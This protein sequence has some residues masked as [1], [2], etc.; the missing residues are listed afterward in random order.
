MNKFAK[1]NKLDVESISAD[2]PTTKINLEDSYEDLVDE[3]K[4]NIFDIN[5]TSD[6]NTTGNKK[7]HLNLYSNLK[8]LSNKIT[9]KNKYNKIK[10][11]MLLCSCILLMIISLIFYNKSLYGCK[12]NDPQVCLKE[13]DEKKI[14]RLLQ[15]LFVSAFLFNISICIVLFSNIIKLIKIVF[16]FIFSIIWY[17]HISKDQG[18]DFKNHGSFNT[19]AF[20]IFNLFAFIFNIAIIVVLKVYKKSKFLSLLIFALFIYL[21]MNINYYFKQPTCIDWEY[22]FN[23]NS[24]NEEQFSTIEKFD[25]NSIDSNNINDKDI[26]KHRS[27]INNNIDSACSITTPLVCSRTILKGMFDITKI[28]NINCNN[29]PANKWKYN[30]SN[31]VAFP[32]IENLLLSANRF[33]QYT[34]KFT[35]T[36]FNNMIEI[37]NDKD[38][39]DLR[40]EAYVTKDYNNND[41]GTLTIDLKNNQLLSD[42]MKFKAKTTENNNLMPKNVFIIFIDSTSRVHFKHSLPKTYSFI[43][44]YYSRN[45]NVR[46]NFDYLKKNKDE[47][48]QSDFNDNLS[49]YQFFKFHALESY[50][51]PN[52]L[53]LYNGIP[54]EEKNNRIIRSAKSIF[55]FY[56]EKG[57]V[58]GSTID[59][60]NKDVFDHIGQN[61]LLNIP[62]T[63][64]NHELHQVFCD[65]NF[66]NINNEGTIWKGQYSMSR[67]CLYGRQS[68]DIV[69]DYAQQFLEKYKDNHKI[70]RLNFITAHEGTG[71]VIKYSDEYLYNFLVKNFEKKDGLLSSNSVLYFFADHS[72]TMPGT[73]SFLRMEDFHKEKYLPFKFVVL[74]KD[75]PL[76]QL[77]DYK[78]LSNENKMVTAYDGNSSL[79]S[80][81]DFNKDDLNIYN[82]L[83]KKDIETAKYI[84]N[85]K[86]ITLLDKM[87]LK[88]EYIKII[89]D[90]YKVDNDVRDYNLY[91]RSIF[92][93][94]NNNSYCENYFDLKGK[95]YCF[96]K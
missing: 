64:I 93:K 81:I 15:C 91:G 95:D 58:S 32:R 14:K 40:L 7:D 22:G 56:K 86:N 77:Y 24:I 19:V 62:P 53:A 39:K 83:N 11:C 66:S 46:Y 88:F 59:M 38:I 21:L 57:Y 73:Y 74:T 71:E 75:V 36:I 54:E 18:S 60:C 12:V 9:I 65:Y 89:K 29:N 17:F 2:L 30:D 44:K 1:S 94:T 76:Y 41:T 51:N 25:I 20:V 92:K 6:N 23:Y 35:D 67:R 27:F 79:L 42:N 87:K 69:I 96:C 4:D 68:D 10:H 43:E 37:N 16:L 70:F 33:S 34:W 5:Y 63:E 49:S 50:S 48:N 90:E 72:F 8:N 47:P 78:L 13:I 3:D 82:L 80:L 84:E 61:F 52:L 85:N 31:K 55:S 45:Q 26:V 28:L